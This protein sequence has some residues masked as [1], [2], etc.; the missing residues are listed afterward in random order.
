MRFV[1]V[2]FRRSGLA[3]TLLAMPEETVRVLVRCRPFNKREIDLGCENVITMDQE[4]RLVQRTHTHTH[5]HA[6]HD[7]FTHHLIATRK[8]HNK[9]TSVGMGACRCVAPPAWR[10]RA[11]TVHCHSSA[12]ARFGASELSDVFPLV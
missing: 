3:L 11:C 9:S 12:S 6:H 1:I 8:Q 10:K 5:T 7:I 4:V 2:F